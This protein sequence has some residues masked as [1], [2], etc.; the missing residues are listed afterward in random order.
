ML[1][2]GRAAAGAAASSD[3]QP[4]GIL[5]TWD[6]FSPEGEYLREVPVAVDE[7]M[8]DGSC[9]LVG[10]GRLVVMRG[11]GSSF[12]GEESAGLSIRG[13]VPEKDGIL[14]CLLVAEMVAAE[15]RSLK[16]LLADLYSRVS[17]GHDTVARE[18]C[19]LLQEGWRHMVVTA[20][21]PV[22]P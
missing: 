21:V 6:V 14:A 15:R 5:E 4:D 11:S 20:A 10:G 3:D 7:A 9:F 19:S 12:G 2:F 16:E 22:P 8:Q 18:R 13:H 17:Y 1:S